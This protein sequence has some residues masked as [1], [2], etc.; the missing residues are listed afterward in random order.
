MPHRFWIRARPV[1]LAYTVSDTFM[2][3]QGGQQIN[4]WH[5]QLKCEP[6]VN[7]TRCLLKE[8]PAALSCSVFTFSCPQ[9]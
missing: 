2:S 9:E 7:K 8:R 3:C 4:L 1:A 6:K 5:C